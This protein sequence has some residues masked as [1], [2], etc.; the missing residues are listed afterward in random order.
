MLTDI[1]FAFRGLRRNPG[2]AAVAILTLALG[3]GATS[4]I[5][6]LVK[7]VM[8]DA[9]P[10]TD[11]DR[12]VFIRG[13]MTRETAQAYPLS[14]L[15]VEA[16]NNERATFTAVVPVTGARSF[17]LTAGDEVEH[18]NGEMIGEGYFRTLGVPIVRGRAFTSEETRS[19]GL[20]VVVLSNG[21]W[22]RR[23]AGRADVVGTTVTLN[24]LPYTVIGIAGAGFGGISDQADLWLPIG[25]SHA[26]YGP[27]YT[28]MRQFRWLSGVGRLAPGVTLEQANTA[29]GALASRLS[30][31]FRVENDKIGYQPTQLEDIYFGGLR[32]PLWALLGAAGFVL[33]I[34]CTNVANLLL[35]RAAVRRKEMALRTALGAQGSRLARQLIVES[36]VLVAFGAVFGLFIAVVALK[37]IVASGA[38]QLQSFLD[39]TVDPL[40]IAATLAISV[41]SALF[42]GLAPALAASRVS[43]VEGLSEGGKGSTGGRARKAFQRSLIAAEVALA[44][45][46]LTGAGL[47]VKGLNRFLQTDLGFRQDSLLTLRVDLTAERYKSNDAVWSLARRL[48]EGARALPGVAHAAVEGPGYP[49]SGWYQIHL[50]P[51]LAEGVG[52]SIPARRHNVSPGYFATIGAQLLAGRDIGP[53]DVAGAERVLVISETLAKR[54]WPNEPAVGKRFRT[55]G[56]NPIT[57]TVVGVVA[58]V[59]HAG[60]Q[61][62]QQQPD[63]YIAVFQSPPRSPSLLTLFVRTTVASASIVDGLRPL[64]REIDCPSAAGCTDSTGYSAEERIVRFIASCAAIVLHGITAS[65]QSQPTVLDRLPFGPH[66]VGFRVAL[67]GSR[68]EGSPGAGES[69]APVIPCSPAQPAACPVTVH[70]WY[71]STDAA[72]KC[73]TLGDYLRFANPGA[74]V[75]ASRERFAMTF[76]AIDDGKWGAIVA[77]RF[78]GCRDAPPA[79]GKHPA[80]IGMFS[81]G[82]WT[83]HGEYFASHGYVVALVTN[84]PGGRPPAGDMT[85]F[86]ATQI[87]RQARSQETLVAWLGGLSNA[88]TSRLGV[89]GQAPSSFLFAMRNPGVVDAVS[90]QDSDIFT[91][92][93]S[94]NALRLAGGW[95]PADL[96]APFLHV[97][98]NSSL[99]AESMRSELDEMRSSQRH[100]LVLSVP[101]TG[102][103]DLTGAGYVARRVLGVDTALVQ[104][105][106]G[107]LQAQHAFFDAYV[108]GDARRRSQLERGGDTLVPSR[109]GT[110]QLIAAERR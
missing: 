98:N 41:A 39:V 21:L 75:A 33:L 106:E 16:L 93:L 53:G 102:H 100:R 1:R 60:L 74:D 20:R 26:L 89:L 43:P 58:D 27:H 85:P 13:T 65:A 61:G 59:S 110:L 108:R 34:A 69:T 63:V 104:A 46:L 54:A 36:L 40:V 17:N 15:D 31:E 22:Q 73:F 50:I 37:T 19:P 56:T 23:F 3:I 67:L 35:A 6:T 97:V 47:M 83:V 62:T 57:L 29:L 32:G 11:A 91:P 95:R 12:L 81:D 51:E 76:P 92:G 7:A 24:E 90:L 25:L 71:P 42:F 66:G 52:A 28:E 79:A 94:P 2:F 88:D 10:Y 84:V 80:L 68:E 72:Q 105:F 9:L 8:V 86:V 55:E 107:M 64:L 70:M 101:H 82:N 87:D 109:V 5:F 77:E 4:A 96:R 45:T 38:I 49:T 99:A 30:A 78:R 48:T 103:E 18:I 44:L 14:V